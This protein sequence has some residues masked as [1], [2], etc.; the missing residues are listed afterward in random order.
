M[1]SGWAEALFSAQKNKSEKEKKEILKRLAVV[2]RNGKKEYLLEKILRRFE[3]I[4]QREKKVELT[5]ARKFNP[6][7]LEKAK[8]KLLNVLGQDRE[9]TTK[10]EEDLIGGFRIKTGNFLIKASFRDFLTDLREQIK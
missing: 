2:L 9:I 1:I 7:F 10:L 6:E 5:L 8:K 3:K 4:F